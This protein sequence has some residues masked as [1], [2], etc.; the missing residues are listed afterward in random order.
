[1]SDVGDQQPRQPDELTT[2][3]GHLTE[4]VNGLR[5]SVDR[6]FETA[7]RA[8]AA[9]RHSQRRSNIAVG[10]ALFAL[11]AGLAYQWWDR[12][13]RD[14]KAVRQAVAACVNAN[15][16]RAAVI[17]GDLTVGDRVADALG[18]VTARPD[19]TPAEQAARA[20][21][22]AEFKATIREEYQANPPRALQPRDCS[23][24]AVTTPTT[25]APGR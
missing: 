9:A 15:A 21:L 24:A 23:P 7:R 4:S 16:S 18:Q 13:Q 25:I 2:E 1:M 22:I 14:D 17:E 19:M 8:V 12:V 5:Q 6:K 20:E 11:F 3:L 10:L